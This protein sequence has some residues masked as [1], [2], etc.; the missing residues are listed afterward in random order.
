MGLA[1]LALDGGHEGGLL[2]A[3]EGAGAQADVD[4]EVEAG[5]KDVLAQQAVLPGLVDGHL[6]AVDGDGILGPDVD[7]ALVAAGGERG[8]HHALND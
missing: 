2:A 5:L 1:P 3:D 7:V 6:E 8:D 4:V